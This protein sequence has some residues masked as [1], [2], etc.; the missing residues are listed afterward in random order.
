MQ[1]AQQE[2]SSERGAA[3][4]LNNLGAIIVLQ[5]QRDPLVPE[6]PSAMMR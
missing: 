6:K 2:G 1:K 3:E 4:Q 5:G